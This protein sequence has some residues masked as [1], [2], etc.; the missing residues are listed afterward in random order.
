MSNG[1]T[2]KQDV[3]LRR[4][5]E[6]FVLARQAATESN[7]HDEGYVVEPDVWKDEFFD[8][9]RVVSDVAPGTG[10]C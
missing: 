9:G 5:L 7:D 1:V 10:D 6:G 8:A 3:A 4:L 2:C